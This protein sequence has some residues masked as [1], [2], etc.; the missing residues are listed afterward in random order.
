M[1][2]SLASRS[3]REHGYT[4]LEARHGADALRQLAES[5]LGRSTW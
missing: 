1:V 3:L 5:S 2:R 4:V